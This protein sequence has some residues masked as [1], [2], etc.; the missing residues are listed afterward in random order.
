MSVE[1]LIDLIEN[2]Q[3]VLIKPEKWLDPLENVISKV[4]FKKDGE[5][6]YI[7]YLK[8]VYGICFT[9]AYESNL[10]WDSYTP[11]GSGVRITFDKSLLIQEVLKNN[12]YSRKNFLYDYVEYVKYDKIISQLKNKNLLLKYFNDP[13]NKL[14]RYLFIK[15]NAYRYEEEYRIIYDSNK[16]DVEY[17]DIITIE[18]DPQLLIEKI[19]FNPKMADTDCWAITKYLVRQNIAKEKIVRSLLYKKKITTIIKI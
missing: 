9:K 11:F 16:D 5:I 19:R 8:N 18:I 6:S 15:R 4:R 3:L 13:N 12:G 7:D 10:M 1:K 17:G 2:Q 14:L